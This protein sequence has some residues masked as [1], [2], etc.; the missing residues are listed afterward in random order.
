MI[1][2]GIA[3]SFLFQAMQSLLQYIASP[4]VLQS[5][6][7]WLFGSLSKTTWFTVLIMFGTLLVVLPFLMMD[8]WEADRLK[9][10][11]EKAAGLGVHV[12][13]CVRRPSF[14]FQS[15]RRGS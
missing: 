8:A 7:F 11:D 12:E 6:V 9:L 10:G 14:L 15:N 3:L 13:S 2:T 1:L 4:E 5:I